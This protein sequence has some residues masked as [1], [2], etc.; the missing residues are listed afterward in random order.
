MSLRTGEDDRPYIDL[1]PLKIVERLDFLRRR[2]LVALL[3][4]RFTS[5]GL[6]EE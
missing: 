2:R 4:P 6:V 1:G 5:F 3:L